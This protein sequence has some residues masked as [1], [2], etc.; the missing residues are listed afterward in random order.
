MVEVPAS[1]EQKTQ[2]LYR[3]QLGLQAYSCLSSRDTKLSTLN[4]VN[5]KQLNQMRQQTFLEA[6]VAGEGDLICVEP[7][8][9]GAN[10]P[11]T[12]DYQRRVVWPL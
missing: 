12:S 7:R 8:L 9:T 10:T 1:T 5:L 11:V 2:G 6:K 3:I 4:A